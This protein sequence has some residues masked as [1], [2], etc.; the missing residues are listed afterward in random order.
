MTQREKLVELI[1]EADSNYNFEWSIGKSPKPRVEYEAEFLLENGVIVPPL[2]VG[3]TVY[4]HNGVGV[5]TEYTIQA[6]QYTFD[7][8]K[9]VWRL[10]LGDGLMPVYPHSALFL[11]REEAEKDSV[12]QTIAFY[13]DMKERAEKDLAKAEKAIAEQEMKNNA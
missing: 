13:K 7:N 3:N 10:D 1:N 8:K 6:M 9:S 12:K 2:K 4:W 5:I 11:T